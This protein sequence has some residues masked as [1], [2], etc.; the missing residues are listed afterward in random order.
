MAR[1][2]DG[3]RTQRSRRGSLTD[4]AVKTAKRR[5]AEATLDKVS[6]GDDVLENVLNFEYLGSRLQCDGDDQV[7]VHHCMDIAQAVFCSLSRLWTD[8]RLSRE[9]KLRHYKLSVCS[10]LTHCCTAWALT[11]QVTRMI[12]GFNSRCLHVITGEDYRVTATT[13]VYD[14]VLAV[15][16]R[17]MRYLGHV[18]RL[19]PDRIVR[20]S[21]I[22][23][24]KGGTCYP[25]GSLFGDCEREPAGTVGH[26]EELIHL[27]RQSGVAEVITVTYEV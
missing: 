10:S 14:L 13:P 7:D 12:N 26:S 24:V 4:T 16:K 2:C 3:G 1:W 11:R 8:H 27:A 21:L 19:P 17:R 20:R 6:I 23:L 5:A 9:T 22:A 18:L 15:R 25:E